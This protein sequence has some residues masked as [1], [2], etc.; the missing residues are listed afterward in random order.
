MNNKL[1]INYRLTGKLNLRWTDYRDILYMYSILKKRQMHHFFCESPDEHN[2]LL[3]AKI[4]HFMG[5]Q[6][7]DGLC[8]S[9]Y[10]E[11]HMTNMVEQAL[12][13]SQ[14][15]TIVTQQKLSICN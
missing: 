14:F 7:M 13:D 1:E 5:I 4:K 6:N 3:K 2:A 15:S 10:C 9:Y 11:L 12:S 8:A